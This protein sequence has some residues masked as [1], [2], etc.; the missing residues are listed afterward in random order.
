[1]TAIGRKSCWMSN[2]PLPRSLAC[3]SGRATLCWRTSYSPPQVVFRKRLASYQQGPHR[4]DRRLVRQG[5]APDRSGSVE[6]TR[7]SR[8]RPTAARVPLR[9]GTHRV[10]PPPRGEPVATSTG[11][12]HPL[13]ADVGQS[14]ASCLFETICDRSAGSPSG[15]PMARQARDGPGFAAQEDFKHPARAAWACEGL[16]TGHASGGSQG[17]EELLF[18]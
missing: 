6:I 9:A 15:L 5:M 7:P 13:L 3:W 1:M 17:L 10:V 18:L 2:P 8:P 4:G 16:P 12:S 14:A 11:R